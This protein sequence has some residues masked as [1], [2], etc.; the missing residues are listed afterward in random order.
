MALVKIIEVMAESSKSWEEAAKIAVKR[1]AKTV[2]NMKSAYVKEQT[3]VIS[4]E[5][6]TAYRVT[7][8]ISFEVS[9]E[10]GFK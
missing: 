7:L 4:G 9:G 6:I 10:T 1:A 8:K 3:T 2:N 5:N